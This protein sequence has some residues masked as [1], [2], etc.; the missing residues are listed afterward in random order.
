MHNGIMS[1][2]TS[3]K[4]AVKTTHTKMIVLKNHSCIPSIHGVPCSNKL[5]ASTT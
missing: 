5:T 3:N 1:K 4:I 2:I